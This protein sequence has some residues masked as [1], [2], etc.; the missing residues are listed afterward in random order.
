MK[1]GRT[2]GRAT[3]V[4]TEPKGN[5]SFKGVEYGEEYAVTRCCTSGL[6]WTRRDGHLG[7]LVH[8]FLVRHRELRVSSE[9]QQL[10]GDPRCPISD[11]GGAW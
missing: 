7:Y 3:P 1:P 4:H 2:S 8:A 11:L 5:A 6:R 9:D 10:A